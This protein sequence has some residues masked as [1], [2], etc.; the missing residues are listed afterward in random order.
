M[1][2]LIRILMVIVGLLLTVFAYHF[3]NIVTAEERVRQLCDQI[4][5]GMPLVELKQFA[6]EHDLV[7]PTDESGIH[8][9]VEQK[10]YGRW[11]CMVEV[12]EGV[13]VS[14]EYR[15]SD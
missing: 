13:V 10:S 1:K 3:Y 12:D 2:T 14:S 9:M 7:P 5:P 6:A 8:P 4:T 11:G 15:Y